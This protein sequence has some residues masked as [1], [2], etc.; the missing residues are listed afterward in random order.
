MPTEAAPGLGV[1]Q[2][3]GG[4]GPS[5]WVMVG[6]SG[7]SS[8]NYGTSAKTIVNCSVW[9]GFCLYYNFQKKGNDYF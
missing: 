9:M 7:E 8:F 2:E 6:G 1:F 3:A 4:A 5:G